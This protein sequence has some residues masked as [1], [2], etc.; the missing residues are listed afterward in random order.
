MT[1]ETTRRREGLT[2]GR[3]ERSFRDRQTGSHS[4]VMNLKE[5]KEEMASRLGIDRSKETDGLLAVR[6][7]ITKTQ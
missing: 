6:V 3:E 2:T 5:L 4:F 1:E 7:F